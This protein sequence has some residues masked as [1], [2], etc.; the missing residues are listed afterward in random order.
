M[1]SLT[2]QIINK[3]LI[4]SVFNETKCLPVPSSTPYNLGNLNS[5]Y[6]KALSFGLDFT[7]QLQSENNEPCKHTFYHKNDQ[8]K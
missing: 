1:I 6:N 7:I 5:I 3:S 8:D 4:I 2:Y